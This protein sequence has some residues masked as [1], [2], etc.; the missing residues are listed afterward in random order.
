MIKEELLDPNLFTFLVILQ[1]VNTDL[2]EEL[3]S[4]PQKVLE[5][6]ESD[7]IPNGQEEWEKLKTSLEIT[8]KEKESKTHKSLKQIRDILF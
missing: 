2:Y 5:K 8:F 6:I 7:L 3:S 4:S 1:S